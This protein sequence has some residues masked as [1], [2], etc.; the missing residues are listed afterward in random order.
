[1]DKAREASTAKEKLDAFKAQ[2]K[3]LEEKKEIIDTNLRRRA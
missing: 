2:A 3:P 1:V